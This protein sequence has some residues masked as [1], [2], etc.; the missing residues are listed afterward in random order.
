[1]KFAD[2]LLTCFIVVDWWWLLISLKDS[3]IRE[4]VTMKI[5][6]LLSYVWWSTPSGGWVA[7]PNSWYMTWPD[8][9]AWL[10]TDFRFWDVVLWF[11]HQTRFLCVEYSCGEIKIS[12]YMYI[13]SAWNLFN[14]ALW[15]FLWWWFIRIVRWYTVIEEQKYPHDTVLLFGC[16]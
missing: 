2:L 8:L 12:C 15:F 7:W 13:Y 5:L 10:T 6:C 3:N 4:T 11:K 16:C 14:E 1:M 9:I